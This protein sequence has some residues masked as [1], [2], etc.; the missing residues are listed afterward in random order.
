MEMILVVDTSNLWSGTALGG[1]THN[2]RT[3]APDDVLAH[4]HAVLLHAAAGGRGGRRRPLSGALPVVRC[5]V[6]AVDRPRGGNRRSG[7]C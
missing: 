5:T 3:V 2:G 1:S 7:G 6:V 4:A